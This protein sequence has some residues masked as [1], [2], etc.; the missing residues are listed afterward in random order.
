M[1]EVE[2]D[3]C[4]ECGVEIVDGGCWG[5]CD[6]CVEKTGGIPFEAIDLLE[7]T[8]QRIAEQGRIVDSR[9]LSKEKM[10]E[11]LLINWENET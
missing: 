3:V 8:R 10:L 2:K 11:Q 5:Y 9:L 1:S 4:L 7:A 6:P